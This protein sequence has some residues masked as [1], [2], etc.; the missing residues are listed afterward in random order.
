MV[1]NTLCIEE[2]RRFPHQA[3]GLGL[4]GEERALTTA[5][6]WLVCENVSEVELP[7]LV[8]AAPV[9]KTE[10]CQTGQA[11]LAIAL[12]GA[13]SAERHFDNL[14]GLVLVAFEQ[15]GPARPW[16]GESWR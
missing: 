11:E 10:K 1:A 6:C 14:L 4:V 2:R 8:K 16:C 5:S 3:S 7:V 13:I 15:T 9:V 12:V